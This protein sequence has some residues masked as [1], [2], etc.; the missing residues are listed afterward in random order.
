MKFSFSSDCGPG[1][2]CTC[3]WYR[4]GKPQTWIEDGEASFGS[5]IDF[6][7][8]TLWTWSV[9]VLYDL[10]RKI[11]TGR[12]ERVIAFHSK[13]SWGTERHDQLGLQV[14]TA[15]LRVWEL[16]LLKLA[17][18]GWLYWSVLAAGSCSI[19]KIWVSTFRICLNLNV[20]LYP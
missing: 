18:R 5:S 19:S 3:L 10:L 1:L 17:E 6:L 4:W 16:L 13:T 9:M 2:E 11:T 7:F 20:L 12:L 14:G 15:S 8:Q